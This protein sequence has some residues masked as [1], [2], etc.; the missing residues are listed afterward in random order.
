MLSAAISKAAS[1]YVSVLHQ[2]AGVGKIREFREK[3]GGE[4][5]GRS[6]IRT[7]SLPGK[8]QGRD[9]DHLSPRSNPRP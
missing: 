3:R 1:F 5:A 8:I 6:E 2:K 7:I 4:K 9:T